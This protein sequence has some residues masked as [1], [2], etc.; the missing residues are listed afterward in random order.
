MNRKKAKMNKLMSMVALSA[1]V[2]L[3]VRPEPVVAATLSWSQDFYVATSS[4]WTWTGATNHA[5]NLVEGGF[6]DWRLPTR[7]EWQA[8]IQ[9]G[10]VGP[11]QPNLP[12]GNYYWTA[13]T[14]GTKAYAITVTTDASGNVI[15]AQSGQTALLVKTSAIYGVAVRP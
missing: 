5:A 7:A 13:D 3:P 10:T 12:Q 15:A 1:I 14:K 2:L 8:A 6:S 4:T 11:L 9:A